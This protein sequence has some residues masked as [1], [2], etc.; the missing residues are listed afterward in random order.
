MKDPPTIHKPDPESLRKIL[1]EGPG[2]YLFKDRADRIIYV[3][4]AKNLKKRVLSYFR[5]FKE[6]P[7]KTGL[8]MN[9][10]EGLDYILTETETGAFI[11]ESSLIKKHLPRYNV[12]LR[13]DKQYPCLRLDIN[14]PYPR[15]RI[16]RKIKKDGAL[17]FGPFSSAQAVRSTLKLI[18]RIFQMRKCKG[19]GLPARSR[20]CLNFQLDRCLGPC[21]H[22]VSSR[23]Y[24]EVVDQVRLFLEGRN[25]ELIRQ[26]KRNMEKA[27]GGLD[28]EKAARIRD[29]IRAVEKVIEGR[30]MASPRLEDRDVI[31]LTQKDEAFQLVILFIRKGYLSGS[32]NYFFTDKGATRSEVLEAFLKQ[33]YSRESFIPKQILVSDPVEDLLSIKDHLSELAGKRVSLDLPRRG[34][35]S[36]LVKMAVANAETL[37]GGRLGD[38]GADLGALARSVMQLKRLPRVIEGLDIS[39]IQGDMAVGAVVS[40]VDGLPNKAGYRNYRIKGV[41]GIDDYAMMAELVSRR[42]GGDS[43]LPDLFLVDGGKGH[44]QAVTKA[45]EGFQGAAETEAAAIAKGEH[46]G[47]NDKVFIP[48]RKNPLTLRGDHPVLHLLM[49]IRDEAHRRA[50]THHRKLRV[51]RLRESRLDTVPGVGEKRKKALLKHFGDLDAI[52]SAAAEDL[53]SVP[54]ISLALAH[55]ILACLKEN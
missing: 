55:E 43:P 51:R 39:N 14:T 23:S 20:P 48:G 32:R 3:G 46:P 54:G 25:R 19:E 50:I 28:F 38:Q 6:L 30:H 35:K 41:E 33:Y 47:E 34:E 45:M 31:G 5:P 18:D 24:G 40:F 44:L 52:R 29:Q 49:R 21:A 7:Y 42:L 27:A 16:V 13:D 26:L 2:V 4:K 22:E 53:A 12:V 36:R 9:R 8:M 1:P 37:L 15:L 17:Y 10:A 11:L